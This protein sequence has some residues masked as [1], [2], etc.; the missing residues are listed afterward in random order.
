MHNLLLLEL[1]EGGHQQSPGIL[2]HESTIK[3]CGSR[4]RR[5]EPET[6]ALQNPCGQSTRTADS[7]HPQEWTAEEEGARNMQQRMVLLP[8]LLQLKCEWELRSQH[9]GCCT[10]ASGPNP[11]SR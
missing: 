10:G 7:L 1:V 3:V 11:S 5:Q 9:L 6:Q 4:R 2:G 8:Q